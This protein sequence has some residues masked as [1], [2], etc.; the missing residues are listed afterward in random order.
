MAEKIPQS[1]E[2]VLRALL[3]GKHNKAKDY[4]GKHVMVAGNKVVPLRKGAA[5]LSDFKKLKEKYGAP[6]V[7][8]FVPRQDISYIL[9]MVLPLP[10]GN[11][12]SPV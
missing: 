11:N 8:T 1:T 4:A 3:S 6:P 9:M 7:L 10:N 12:K 2:K 5:G